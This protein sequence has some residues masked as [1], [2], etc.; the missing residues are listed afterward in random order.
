M[1]NLEYQYKR[2]R[3]RNLKSDKVHGSKRRKNLEKITYKTEYEYDDS[4]FEEE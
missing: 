1:T 3:E 4:I 2:A